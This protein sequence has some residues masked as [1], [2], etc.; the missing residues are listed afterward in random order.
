MSGKKRGQ[1]PRLCPSKRRFRTE[2]DAKLALAR[3]QQYADS[4]PNK[5]KARYRQESRAYRCPICRG[6][7]LTSQKRGERD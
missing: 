6:W 4:E 7:H 5:Q 3:V 1:G 2:L